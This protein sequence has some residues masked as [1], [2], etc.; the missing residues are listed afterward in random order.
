MD[1]I[2]TDIIGVLCDRVVMCVHRSGQAIVA[3]V[4]VGLM[5]PL[6]MGILDLSKIDYNV[7]RPD[8]EV[9]LRTIANWYVHNISVLFAN[10][11]FN[12]T[13]SVP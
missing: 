8:V 2:N 13:L 12:Y 5:E 9:M 1:L 11:V 7:D 6:M 3:S 10:N 4:A